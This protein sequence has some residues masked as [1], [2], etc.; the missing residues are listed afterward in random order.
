MSWLLLSEVY[1]IKESTIQNEFNKLKNQSNILIK[2]YK[3]T[4]LK[5]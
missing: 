3:N 1:K 4:I 2:Y 5:N